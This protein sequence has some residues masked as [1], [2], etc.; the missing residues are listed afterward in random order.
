M[1]LI[2]TAAYHIQPGFE[3]YRAVGGDKRIIRNRAEHRD[4][5]KRFNKVEIGN[6]ASMAPPKAEPGEFEHQQALKK[7]EIEASFHENTKLAADLASF[8]GER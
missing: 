2:I 3:P 4:F 7:R 6:D 5:L 1:S 8:T